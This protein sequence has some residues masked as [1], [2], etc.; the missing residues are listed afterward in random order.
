MERVS[1]SGLN[2]LDLIANVGRW[3]DQTKLVNVVT[4]IC[5]SAARFYRLCLPQKWSSYAELTAVL[6]LQSVQSSMFHERKQRQN[7]P[8]TVD[9]YAK[10]LCKLFHRAYPTAQQEEGGMAANVLAYHFVAGLID[11]L[12]AK[13]VGTKGTFEELLTKAHFEEARRKEKS[14]SR[15]RAPTTVNRNSGP[16]NSL[17]RRTPP[18]SDCRC[19]SCG[20]AGHLARDC[21]RKG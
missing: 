2:V 8:E 11:P 9:P 3:D 15:H 16:K 1:E 20:G 19:F 10:E 5:G 21:S 6:R 17:S 4:R 18:Q 13:L 14:S 7:P 12:K